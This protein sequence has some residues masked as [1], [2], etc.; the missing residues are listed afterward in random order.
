MSLTITWKDNADNETSQNVYLCDAV[1]GSRQ[2]MTSVGPDVT[3]ATVEWPEGYPIPAFFTVTAMSSAAESEAAS[4]HISGGGYKDPLVWSGLVKNAA[5]FGAQITDH[6]L[7]PAG[8]YP[9]E[10][11][12]S[13]DVY[14]L[15]NGK[16]FGLY[17]SGDEWQFRVVNP[18]TMQIEQYINTEAQL[19]H[20]I[21]AADGKYYFTTQAGEVVKIKSFDGV[22]IVQVA[23]VPATSILDHGVFLSDSG[24]PR[25]FSYAG[26]EAWFTEYDTAAE[27][28][29]KIDI[30]LPVWDASIDKGAIE[31]FDRMV[32][33]ADDQLAFIRAQGYSR[34]SQIHVA[35]VNQNTGGQYTT[36][37]PGIHSNLKQ[38]NIAARMDRLYLADK[39]HNTL[40]S[41]SLDPEV[42][43]SI[44]RTGGSVTGVLLELPN[45]Q[46]GMVVS[47][48]QN[49]YLKFYDVNGVYVPGADITLLA[50]NTPALHALVRHEKGIFFCDK[51]TYTTAWLEL[52]YDNW[53]VDPAIVPLG[54]Y[55]SSYS[56]FDSASGNNGLFTA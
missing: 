36:M 27:L 29:S 6:V 45:G 38:T 24:N 5:K 9:H 23:S 7:T 10:L 52:D 3:S 26:G 11:G 35:R 14:R 28:A 8:P 43:H 42:P 41:I 46:V 54:N 37:L 22:N 1:G 17:K 39:I 4:Y 53:H 48:G 18:D 16:L 33:I 21:V 40:I 51:G 20:G 34:D 30:K 15:G 2:L 47:I 44:E 31:R 13:N 25:F 50:G 49:T 55:A 12:T 32:Y 56:R 19:V